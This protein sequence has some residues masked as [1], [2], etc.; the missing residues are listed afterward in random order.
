MP[1]RNSPRANPPEDARITKTKT[2]LDAALMQLVEE[3]DFGDIT[4]CEICTR[5][6]VSRAAFYA[7]FDDKFDLMRHAMFSEA[8]RLAEH[9]GEIDFAS[10]LA[11]ALSRLRG[12]KFVVRRVTLGKFDSE[13]ALAM[14][15]EFAD[16]IRQ[17]VN[18]GQWRCRHMGLPT[19]ACVSYCAH[20]IA[21]I[22][23][24]WIRDGLD[25]EET[26]V[27]RMATALV[28]STFAIDE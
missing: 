5:A 14:E 19:E 2:A 24:W 12:N 23:L 25:A 20:G 27:A 22:I 3:K 26:R 7:H 6:H 16:I 21:G 11:H 8:E 13:T 9:E 17:R 4:I 28:A 18:A 15:E 1:P 10:L